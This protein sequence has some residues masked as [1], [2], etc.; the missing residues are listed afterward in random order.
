[1]IH[2]IYECIEKHGCG[3]CRFHVRNIW[4]QPCWTCIFDIPYECGFKSSDIVE[5]S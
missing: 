3:W 5:E 1:M 2:N 4:D